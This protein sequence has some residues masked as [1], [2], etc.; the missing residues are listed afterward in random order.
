VTYVVKNGTVYRSKGCTFPA[1]CEGIEHFLK[2]IA[3]DLEKPVE[4]VVNDYDWPK[5]AKRGAFPPVFSFSKVIK[6][7]Q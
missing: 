1:R 7:V 6:I 5:V 3:P 4:F 2:E